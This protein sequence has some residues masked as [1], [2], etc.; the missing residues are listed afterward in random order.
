MGGFEQA[1]GDEFV[2]GGRD[3]V[4]RV[5]AE[6]EAELG[7]VDSGVEAEAEEEGFFEGLIWCDVIDFRQRQR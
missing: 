1:G 4:E 6:L 7:E 5:F 3:F 2:D